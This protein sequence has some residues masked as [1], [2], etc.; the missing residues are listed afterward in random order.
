MDDLIIRKRKIKDFPSLIKITRESFPCWI[1]HIPYLFISNVFVAERNSQAVGFI[2]ILT[3]KNIAQITLTAITK[4][5]R[6]QNLG[7]ELLKEILSYLKSIKVKLCMTK[8]R[9][10]NLKA[11]KFYENNG[12]Q[13]QKILKRPILGD[14][15]LI[16]KDI[17]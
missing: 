10:D 11:L 13:V 17:I 2:A 15:F 12:F 6:G 5:Y 7:S 8:V 3:K 1:K 16:K 4:D 14:V 9:I